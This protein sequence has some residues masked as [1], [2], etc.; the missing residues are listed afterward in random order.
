MAVFL[1]SASAATELLVATGRARVS[2]QLK[3]LT[4]H[5]PHS[6]ATTVVPS[7]LLPSDCDNP[8][9]SRQAGIAL[10]VNAWC[11]IALTVELIR[12]S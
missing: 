8:I 10:A 12:I 4:R 1:L 11:I 2:G 7:G 6:H 5:L 3:S 9:G